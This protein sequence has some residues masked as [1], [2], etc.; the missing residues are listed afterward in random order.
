ME[1]GGVTK[2]VLARELGV[3]HVHV[4]NW[5]NGQS[6]RIEQFYGIAKFFNVS[7]EWLFNGEE[8]TEQGPLEPSDTDWRH[9]AEI[10]EKAISKVR[11]ALDGL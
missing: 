8:P 6:P 2:A 1:K 7:M 9:R 10:A 3:S 4:L 11:E 5:L